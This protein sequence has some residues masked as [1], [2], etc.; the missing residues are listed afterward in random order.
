MKVTS[1][2]HLVLT[3]ADIEATVHF[4]AAILGCEKVVF[5]DTGERVALRFGNQKINLHQ[6]DC[7]IAPK[8]KMPVPGSADLCFLVDCSIETVTEW[9]GENGVEI[10][11]G[12]VMR[13]GA[14]GEIKSVYI[15]DPD[16]NL[17][18]LSCLSV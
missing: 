17:L 1:L 13:T 8:A 9:L 16:A 15:R 12:P 2:D 5:G 6:V 11:D 10:I 3:V 7:D 4:Y 18:E 14:Q